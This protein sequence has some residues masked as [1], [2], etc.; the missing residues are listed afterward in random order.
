MRKTRTVP[1][2]KP[3]DIDTLVE[4]IMDGADE[5]RIAADYAS[6]KDWESFRKEEAKNVEATQQEIRGTTQETT[7]ENLTPTLRA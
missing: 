3:E 5:I 6:L 7:Q 2:F 1:N 4:Y